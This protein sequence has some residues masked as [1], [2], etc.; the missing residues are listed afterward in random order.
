[1]LQAGA[2][3]TGGDVF[4][5][6]MGEPIKIGDLARRMIDLSGF[7]VREDCNPDGDI[8]ISITGL[9][10]G[11][12]LF[13][14]LLL[15]DNPEKTHHPRIMKAKEPFIAWDILKCKVEALECALR[16][17][18]AGVIASIMQKLV[19]GYEPSLEIRDWMLTE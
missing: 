4:V 2:L 12:K 16:V 10:P 3:A 14:E 17:N 7:T 11:E 8:A 15:G 18:D 19:Q 1:V 5:L 6:D 9:R 13:E